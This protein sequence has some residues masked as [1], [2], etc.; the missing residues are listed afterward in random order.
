MLMAGHNDF[1]DG[2]HEAISAPLPNPEPD[3]AHF[4]R[5]PTAA[6]DSL[7]G[8]VHAHGVEKE[9]TEPKAVWE[10]VVADRTGNLTITSEQGTLPSHIRII[11]KDADIPVILNDNVHAAIQQLPPIPEKDRAMFGSFRRYID[12]L[13]GAMQ[14]S[15][16]DLQPIDLKTAA[17]A[18]F[19]P[20]LRIVEHDIS[21][22]TKMLPQHEIEYVALR[23]EMSQRAFGAH[24]DYLEKTGH[25]I[26]TV[27]FHFMNSS[28]LISTQNGGIEVLDRIATG[29]HHEY[30]QP[31]GRSAVY[32]KDVVHS[33]PQKN[34]AERLIAIVVLK[35]K[36][37]H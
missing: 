28:T 36:G 9:I 17:E 1:P 27:P 29:T 4:D 34:G 3:A 11:T 37:S 10:R 35:E 8:P 13:G 20:A 24:L 7:S 25:I 19:A 6:S 32:L 23:T 18:H 16:N 33:A 2:L 30:I 31:L 22:I 5:I 21:G 14:L 12:S 26:V 15:P